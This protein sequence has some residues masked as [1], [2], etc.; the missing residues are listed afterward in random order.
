MT[1]ARLSVLLAGADWRE[2][3]RRVGFAG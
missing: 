1:L 3:R 2:L